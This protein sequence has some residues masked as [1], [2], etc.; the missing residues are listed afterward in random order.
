[1]TSHLTGPNSSNVLEAQSFYKTCENITDIGSQVRHSR[2]SGIRQQVKLRV[3]MW[4]DR[5]P[6]CPLPYV[7]TLLETYFNR[8]LSSIPRGLGQVE[9]VPS[10]ADSWDLGPNIIMARFGAGQKRV[11]RVGYRIIY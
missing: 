7:C 10:T 4:L 11:A 9:K 8:P 1:M 6:F 5:D 2:I 3:F